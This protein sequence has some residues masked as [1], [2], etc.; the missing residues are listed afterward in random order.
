MVRLYYAYFYPH[1]IIIYGIEFYVHNA[2]CRLNQIYLRKTSVLR[3]ILK[4]RRGDHVTTH[5]EQLKIM[6]IDM[7]SKYTDFQYISTK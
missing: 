3:I 2:N 5:L 4:I 1:L 7:L 6:P